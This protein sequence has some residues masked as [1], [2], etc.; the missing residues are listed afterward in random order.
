MKRT[1]LHS[2]A[3]GVMAGAMI[4]SGI[5][6][7]EPVSMAASKKAKTQTAV[8]KALTGVKS[9]KTTYYIKKTNLISVKGKKTKVLAKQVNS[10]RISGKNIYY[11]R[12]FSKLYR[13]KKNGTSKKKLTG[14]C[15][16]ILGIH[17]SNIHYT[18]SL[19]VYRIQTNGKGKKKIFRYGMGA[20]AV[21]SGGR[22]YA[23][24]VSSSTGVLVQSAKYNGSDKKTE[25][26]DATGN[27]GAFYVKNNQ[28]RVAVV[29]K[30]DELSLYT[31]DE[32]GAWQSKKAD[33]GGKRADYILYDKG[34]LYAFA[35]TTVYQVNETGESTVILELSEFGISTIWN[36]GRFEKKGAYWILEDYGDDGGHCVY[37]IHANTKK[38]VKTLAMPAGNWGDEEN[39]DYVLK[40]GTVYVRYSGDGGEALYKTYTLA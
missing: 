19:G 12:N 29:N 26:T 31:K 18:G 3:A 1:I 4:L 9:G 8:E 5:T 40:K 7:N 13:M 24:Y 37:L 17:G 22:I 20:S 35:G 6:V 21:C 34:K 30:K 32:N 2:L 33:L 25:F 38:L 23:K 36:F 27:E 39:I 11:V 14:T 28:L 16:R 15:S 10:F